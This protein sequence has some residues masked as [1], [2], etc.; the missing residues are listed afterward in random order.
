M[1]SVL[2]KAV[3]AV[4]ALMFSLVAFKVLSSTDHSTPAISGLPEIN[5]S[6]LI[7]SSRQLEDGRMSTVKSGSCSTM[8]FSKLVLQPNES[9]TV[10]L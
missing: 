8:V 1:S 6:N 3:V 4:V 7:I 5:N 10:T 9:V 2:S